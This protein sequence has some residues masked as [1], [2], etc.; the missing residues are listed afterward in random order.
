MKFFLSAF[1]GIGLI[2]SLSLGAV[3]AKTASKRIAQAVDIISPLARSG[4]REYKTKPAKSV[5]AALLALAFK[6]KYISEVSEFS[7]VGDSNEAWDADS[8]NWGETTMK[9]AY[10][11][12]THEDADYLEYLKE[13][14]QKKELAQWQ[15]SLKQ[16]KAAFKKLVGTGVKFG[17]APLG[18]VQCG[19]TFAALAIIDPH[20]GKIYVFAREGSGC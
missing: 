19:V 17:V 6:E 11:Y 3:P 5:K 18:A 2:G 15:K 14:E 7:W 8:T 20:T 1:V 10:D 16:S 12:V 13:P 4:V 9:G